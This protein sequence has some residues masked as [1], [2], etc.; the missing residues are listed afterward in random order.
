MQEL[1]VRLQAY[2]DKH[3]IGRYFDLFAGSLIR[4]DYSGDPLV[5][6]DNLVGGGIEMYRDFVGMFSYFFLEDIGCPEGFAADK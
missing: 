5:L 6:A 3:A 2:E 1:A 4:T